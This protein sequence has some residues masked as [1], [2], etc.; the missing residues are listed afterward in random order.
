[1]FGERRIIYLQFEIS[2]DPLLHL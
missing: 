2:L 1:V